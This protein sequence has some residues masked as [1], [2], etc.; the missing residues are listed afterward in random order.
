MNNIELYTSQ[1]TN[2]ILKNC[3]KRWDSIL[4]EDIY[5]N[6]ISWNE[7]NNKSINYALFLK[8]NWIQ[9]WDSIVIFIK[10]ITKFSY[11]V[12]ASLLVWAKVVIIEVDYWEKLLEEK[13]K[14]IKPDLLIIDSFL[15]KILKIPILNKFKK[16][17]KYKSLL[18]YSKKIIIDSKKD[19]IFNINNIKYVE[20]NVDIESLVVFTWWTTSSPKWVVHTMDSISIMLTRISGIIWKKTKI[21][22]ADLPHFVLIWIIMWVKV[23]VWKNNISDLKYFSILKKFKIDTIFS[24]PYRYLQILN[25][26]SKLPITLKHICLW[27][28]PIYK[29][30]LL[31]LYEKISLDTKVSCIYWMTELLP[32]SYIDWKEKINSNVNWDLLW[33]PMSG[34]DINILNDFELELSWKWLFKKYLWWKY[35][36]NHKTWDL[37]EFIDWKLIMKW[38]KKDMILR[39]DYNIYPSLYESIINSIPGVTDSALVWIWNKDIEDEDIY[40]FIE[41][42]NLSKKNIY[43]NLKKWKY[44]IDECTL[45]NKII[46][47]V[48]PRKWRQNKIDKKDLRNNYEKYENSYNLI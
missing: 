30:F 32:I 11:I 13:L 19:Y 2:K 1:L 23:V 9:L 46:F 21:F 22:Y 26:N 40:L 37:V 25:W 36:K 28:A 44:S 45:P 39:K 8:N 27:S 20:L 34:I 48:L 7:Y 38:R 6:R 42:Y 18:C 24:P 3:Y 12:L 4:I 33:V 29:S 15:Y 17:Y 5:W 41:W 10:D 47:C 14:F 31:K 43:N 35:I 16:I